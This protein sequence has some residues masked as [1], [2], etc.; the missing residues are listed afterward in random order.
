MKIILTVCFAV[1]CFSVQIFAQIP[2]ATLVNIVR[3]EDERRYDK[4]LEDSLKSP[5][6]KI[7]LRAALAAGRIGDERAIP[8][9]IS[10]L[11]KDAGAVRAMAA[12]ALGEI[13]SLK[14]AEA[15]LKNLANE[16]L[17]AEVRARL[18]EAAGKMA[19]ANAK[20]QQAIKLGAAILD[21]LDAEMKK[22]K[23]NRTTVLLGLTA[24]LRARPEEGASVAAKFLTNL[25]GRIRA[26]AANTLS[27]LRA[28]NANEPLRAMLLADDDANARANAAR[29]LGAAEDKLA[30][31]LLLEAAVSDEDSRV[32]VSAIR[33]LGNLKDRRVADKLL[34]RG[35]TLLID[36]KKSKLTL[37][38]EKSELLEITAS[39]GKLLEK[40]DD[41]KTVDF[42]TAVGSKDNFVSPEIHIALAK[43]SPAK[44]LKVTPP[45]N[46]CSGLS[47]RVLCW[48]FESSFAQGLS[49]LA[50]LEE[51]GSPHSTEAANI[52]MSRLAIDKKSEF[53]THFDI[54]SIPEKLRAL[55][56]LKPKN[57]AEVLRDFLSYKDVI[58]RATA[59][60]LLG[61]LPP[62]QMRF[63][64]F[65]DSFRLALEDEKSDDALLATIEAIGKQKTERAVDFLKDRFY[66]L[67]KLDPDYGVSKSQSRRRIAALLNE[68]GA[69]NFFDQ[70]GK[71]NSTFTT[72][73]YTRTVVRKNAKA[74]LTTDKGTFAIEFTPEAAPLTVDNFIK[75]AKSNYYNGLMIHRVVPNF[76]MQDGDPRGDG[77]G[78]PGYSIR[79]EINTVEYERGAV[80]MA[81]SGKDTGGSQWFV[82]HA[83]QPH[84][85]G[86]Y[87][88]FGRVNETDMKV[89]DKLVRGDKIRTVKIIE[90]STPPKSIKSR[91]KI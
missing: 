29:A 28:K 31:D 5:D 25:D 12:F 57:S 84:L 66:A 8:T 79:C 63:G 64:D 32:R 85:D 82:T 54:R 52:L 73:D 88:V 61:D 56:K 81:L 60:E 42:L 47:T 62:E 87:T 75:L 4:T 49:E 30:F 33:S 89:V 7:R 21:V 50:N 76:V 51:N 40:S 11:E 15:V 27:R 48:Q 70:L 10:L 91:H 83:P 24:I 19:A 18:T 78:G 45:N 20:D 86:G 36:Y 80:G 3:A 23:S 68:K 38:N 35:N 39:L 16:K 13:E 65:E 72:A 77:N 9:L 46:I 26:D 14:A 22:P 67:S 37:P 69:G 2:T 1:L 58:V 6:E 43:I 55:A 59:I 44:F 90:G 34:E 41:A 71:V 17:A 53:E 74:I